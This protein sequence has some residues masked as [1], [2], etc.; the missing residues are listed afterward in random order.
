M[1]MEKC[2]SLGP[3][4]LDRVQKLSPKAGD[5]V[6]VFVPSEDWTYEPGAGPVDVAI[7]MLANA[8]GPQGARVASGFV[9]PTDFRVEQHDHASLAADLG[10]VN[11]KAAADALRQ[12]AAMEA[13]TAW[14]GKGDGERIARVLREEADRIEA[15]RLTT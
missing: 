9:L 6:L 13:Y 15:G 14:D 1:T 12:R 8:L 4:F 3:E 5:T 2:A 10:L 7:A 11:A